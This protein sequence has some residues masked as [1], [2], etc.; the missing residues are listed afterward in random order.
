MRRIIAIAVCLSLTPT[1]AAA[2]CGGT[3]LVAALK[4]SD[5]AA[6]NA[7]FD[8]AHAVPNGQGVFW[9]VTAG[10]A[11][12]SYL[13]GTFADTELADHALNPVVADAL[14]GARLVMVEI[15]AAEQQRLDENLQNDPAYAINIDRSGLT[16]QLTPEERA[17]AEKELTERGVPF[18]I[19]D[20]LRPPILYSIISVPL[21]VTKQVQDGGK[22]LSDEVDAL[23]QDAGVAIAGLETI[24]RAL[25]S[26]AAVP[27]I[28]V[29]LLAGLRNLNREED[30]HRTAVELYKQGEVSAMWEF[31][32]MAVEQ[33]VGAEP[34]R[35]AM[36]Q[37]D[38]VMLGTR[39]KAWV[40]VMAPELKKGG[41]FVAVSAA[42]FPGPDGLVE[43]LRALDFNVVRLDG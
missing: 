26:V 6:Y 36:E 29:I 43:L 13:F 25:G 28:D 34:G 41:V 30:L 11:P 37:L 39:S 12:P 18:E 24:E 42:H 19:V 23:A 38:A 22:T 10:D 20:K 5:E 7:M 3:D 32:T 40:E 35:E 2:Q 21:C 4:E 27:A 33:A 15:T 31:G 1:L 9:Q 17:M 14:K 16:A 8:R